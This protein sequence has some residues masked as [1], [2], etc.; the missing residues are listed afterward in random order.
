MK[1]LIL[2]TPVKDSLVTTKDTIRSLRP[3]GAEHKYYIFDDYSTEPTRNWLDKN[4]S[5][6]NYKVIGLETITDTPSPNYRFTLQ[7]VQKMALEQDAGVVLIESDVLAT[8]EIINKLNELAHTMPDAGMVGAVTVDDDGKIN[9]PYNYVKEEWDGIFESQRSLSFCCTLLTNELLQKFSFEELDE[10][11][12]WYDVFI[13]KKSRQL[14]F[15]NYLTKETPVIHR[16]HS[17]RPW[18]NLKYTNPVLY[19][20]KKFFYGKDKI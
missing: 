19:Y 12:D 5:K 16:P 14:G 3:N 1:K 17:S 4:E 6:Y 11:K 18:K 13:T 15:K 8:P 7:T 9:F 10:S 2:V 20:F